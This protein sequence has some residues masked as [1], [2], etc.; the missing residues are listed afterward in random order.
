MKALIAAHAAREPGFEPGIRDPKSPVIPL[1]HSR[2]EEASEN[3]TGRLKGVSSE[4]SCDRVRLTLGRCASIETRLLG[5]ATQADAFTGQHDADQP[6]PP[7][8][9]PGSVIGAG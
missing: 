6:P 5:A 4:P 7:P 1:H 3:A 2:I 8:S 9:K